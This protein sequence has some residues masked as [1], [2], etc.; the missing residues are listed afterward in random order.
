MYITHHCVSTVLLN[1]LTEIQSFEG[2]FTPSNFHIKVPGQSLTNF[3]RNGVYTI[4]V[5]QFLIAV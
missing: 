5:V 4:K 1:E 2:G 3:E